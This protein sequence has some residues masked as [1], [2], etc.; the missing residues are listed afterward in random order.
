MN[1]YQVAEPSAAQLISGDRLRQASVE[2]CSLVGL[3]QFCVFSYF[4]LMLIQELVVFYGSLYGWQLLIAQCFHEAK[5]VV[6]FLLKVRLDS[7]AEV[8]EV[9]LTDPCLLMDQADALGRGPASSCVDPVAGHLCLSWHLGQVVR[10][11]STDS[12]V[13]ICHKY[14]T[15]SVLTSYS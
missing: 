8:S 2:D 12:S 1:P 14:P 7:Q 6:E 10:V 13:H 11:W 15:L 3:M 5:L 9:E 4:H